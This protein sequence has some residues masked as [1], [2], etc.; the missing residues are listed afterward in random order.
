MT[1]E[2]EQL[3]QAIA[4]MEAQ[5]AILG[6]ET[7]DTMIA[8]AREKLAALDTAVLA[9][10]QRKQI[11]VL[12]ADV[13]GFT[14]MSETMD[15]EDVSDTMNALWT[16]I[17]GAITAYGGTIDKHI[18]DAVM[19]L[20]G[21][22]AAREDDPERAIRAAL[23]MQAE[24]A[25]FREERQVNLAMR[26][27]I[28]T[29]PVLLGQ[30]GTTFEYTAI[31]DTVNLA[32]RLESA[33]PVGSVLISRDTYRHV[34]GVF[35]FQAPEP[36]RVAGKAESVQVYVVRGIK[37]RAFRT[38][39]RGVEGVETRMI[40]RD[41]ELDHLKKALHAILEGDEMRMVTIVGDAGIGKSRLLYEFSNGVELLPERVLHFRGR[42]SQQISNA[43]YSLI[44]DLLASH[45]EIKNS[46]SADEARDKLE[47]G[48]FR[49]MGADATTAAVAA[50]FVGHLIGLD[51]S[52]SP[53][54][55]GVLSDA[56][57]IHDRAFH[58]TAQF[59][60]AAAQRP[61]LLLL[62]DLHWAD[63]GSLDLIEHLAQEC[64]LMPLLI[65]ALTR[66]ELYERRAA[67]AG[68][69]AHQTRLELCPLSKQEGCRLVGEI[70][71][72]VERIPPDLRDLIVERAAGNPF[73]TEELIK[74]LIEDEV[75][76]KGESGW[77]VEPGRLARVQVPP[78]LTGVL[79]ARLDSLPPL[80]REVLQRAA[81]V[82]RVFWDGAVEQL[83]GKSGALGNETDEALAALQSKELIFEQATSTFIGER[84]FVFKHAILHDVTYESVLVRQRRVYHTRAAVWLTTRSGERGAEY[85]GL[86][87]EHYEQARDRAQA[88]KWYAQAGWQAQDTYAP[89]AAIGY[90]RKALAF[91]PD[92]PLEISQRIELYQRLGQMLLWQTRFEEATG[93]YTAMREA[94]ETAGD[95]AAQARAWEG[96]SAVQQM[97]GDNRAALESAG[98]AEEIAQAAG[99]PAQETLARA[100]WRKGQVFSDLG[101]A[102]KALS[103]GEQALALGAELGA[104]RIVADSLGLLGWVHQTLGRYEQAV[105]YFEQALDLARELDDRVLA[106]R[107]LTTLGIIAAK[108]RRDYQKAAAFLHEALSIVQGIGHRFGEI[109]ILHNLAGVWVKM[110][111]YQVAETD[112]RRVIRI[113]ETVGWSDLSATYDFLAQAYLGQGKVTEALAAARR[114]LELGQESELQ[115]DIGKAWRALGMTLADASAPESIAIGEDTLDAPACFARSLQIF[116]ET[117]MEDERARTLQAWA[118]Y[119]IE[120]GDEE[121]GQEMSQEAREIFARL[122]IEA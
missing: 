19:A 46:D 40:G 75:I 21:A 50:H 116:A 74:M 57:Q 122:G 101:E 42:A 100:L 22:P 103:L 114:A 120:R 113:A 77:S 63:D 81:V 111:K 108:S 39:T 72:G 84:E 56:R 26:I 104:K 80:E 117:G 109:V 99:A 76:V 64:H 9:A 88:A 24:L 68:G 33:A 67:W 10:P 66:P 41:A 47:Q 119:E 86:I 93:T 70:L 96:L 71:R 6:D 37:P 11:T 20:F 12:F 30:V 27:G 8:V 1:D 90:Y 15:A 4:A 29:G 32:D 82:G 106:G 79:Q 69:S 98:R 73:Y 62:D 35:S 115:E 52:A 43:P 89:E 54:L 92:G 45:F 7:V 78:A 48:I 97:Q 36:L 85:A 25:A 14:A 60:T 110:A 65:V 87:G 102:E 16:R 112:L 121:R 3:E 58:Y 61:V 44:R 28:N 23:A 55:Q 59:F 51:F 18:G 2:R 17:D 53:Y 107:T 94:A 105:Y 5:R 31:G 49:L 13:S 34:R 95:L 91:L 118:R 83:N 38:P